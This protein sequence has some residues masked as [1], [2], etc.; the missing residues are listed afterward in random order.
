M[1]AQREQS[2]TT[3]CEMSSG[4]RSDEKILALANTSLGR[5]Q[6]TPASFCSGDNSNS[7]SGSLIFNDDNQQVLIS[8]I[9]RAGH[10]T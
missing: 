3:R 1:D 4:R 5:R 9:D 7:P 6:M 8:F 2:A 10:I